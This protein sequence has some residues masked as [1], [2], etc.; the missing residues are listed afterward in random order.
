MAGMPTS[1]G[2]IAVNNQPLAAVAELVPQLLGARLSIEFLVKRPVA[3]V[4]SL[5]AEGLAIL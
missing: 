4:A 5:F 3:E 2:L 1:V